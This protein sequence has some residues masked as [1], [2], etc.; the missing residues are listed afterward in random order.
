MAL[1][2]SN[3]SRRLSALLVAG[4]VVLAGA[5]VPTSIAHAAGSAQHE[6]GL[7]ISVGD[8]TQLT[9]GQ[10]DADGKLTMET[11]GAPAATTY[12]A[13]AA[14]LPTSSLYAIANNGGTL[15][16]I[17]DDGSVE[18]VINSDGGI[19]RF[20]SSSSAAAFGAGAFEDQLFYVANGGRELGCF[21]VVA[22]NSCGVK[23][24]PQKFEPIGMAWNDGF[25][26]GL[27]GTGNQAKLT[28]V[29]LDG[30][31]TPGA[32]PALDSSR[33]KSGSFGAA[34]TYGNGNLGF[35]SNGGGSVQI[36]IT[37]VDPIAAEV[38][39]YSTGE[40]SNQLDGAM[41]PPPP[42]DV[43]LKVASER[44][45]AGDTHLVTATVHNVGSTLIT[46]YQL[47]LA[48]DTADTRPVT[49]P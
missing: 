34:W 41:I 39:G 32:I 31:V 45:G 42:G 46:G 5:I 1:R 3:V 44:T 40:T 8:P 25:F 38:V 7:Y 15:L 17:L 43:A 35:M 4:A 18:N 33:V 11:V 10:I 6:P 9:R 29:S 20:G 30:A 14:H 22:S 48:P 26:W 12:N 28:R 47:R 2:A 19:T 49:A 23:T 27:S 16:R 24:L 21:D 37:S 13:L 36:K